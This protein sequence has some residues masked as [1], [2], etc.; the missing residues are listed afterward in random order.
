MGAHD[1]VIKDTA[2]SYLEL[3]PSTVGSV[4]ASARAEREL[5]QRTRQRDEI[6]DVLDVDAKQ[7]V[8]SVIS[9]IDTLEKQYGQDLDVGGRDYLVRMR[10][11]TGQ[12]SSIL[13]AISFYL[14]IDPSQIGFVPLSVRTIVG[15]VVH[16]LKI[17]GYGD[18]QFEIGNLPR[19]IGDHGLLAE[20][21]RRLMHSRLR[22][23]GDNPAAIRVSGR[24][25]S[26]VCEVTIEDDFEPF[27]PKQA[28]R[29]D[30]ILRPD[31]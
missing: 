25:L 24:R 9:S 15:K 17:D 22:H 26:A 7:A 8:D 10:E 21:F 16:E 28:E 4:I 18:V 3:L 13:A 27:A 20:L 12:L 5:A 29:I 23:R 31:S 2:G 14:R 11:D 30:Q 6:A 1:F 19:A